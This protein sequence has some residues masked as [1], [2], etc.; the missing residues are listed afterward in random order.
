MDIC[1][2]IIEDQS[3]LYIED[4]TIYK[5][6][7]NSLPYNSFVE[8]DVVK[9]D[10]LLQIDS[11]NPQGKFIKTYM[12]AEIPITKDGWYRIIHLVIPTFNWLQSV[13]SD[14]LEYYNNIYIWSNSQIYKYVDHQLQQIDI[15]E[16][17]EINKNSRTTVSYSSKDVFNTDNLQKC[18]VSLNSTDT[19]F[20]GKKTPDPCDY[21]NCKRDH[22]WHMLNIIKYYVH[23]GNNYEALRLL[24]QF[25]NCFEFCNNKSNNYNSCACHG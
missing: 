22:T 6:D 19:A 3:N 9:L 18:L 4:T 7:R 15:L 11:S 12:D 2:N 10:L 20:C 21:N 1:F 25:N 14:I 13:S 23:C 16:L 5:E 24:E 17:L 8:E